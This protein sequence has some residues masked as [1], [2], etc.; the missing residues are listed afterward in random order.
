MPLFLWATP[1][2]SLF[3]GPYSDFYTFHQAGRA[4]LTHGNPYNLTGHAAGFIYP[5]ASL[6][7]YGIFA[8]F[9]FQY[10]STLW[11]VTY[12]SV[13][14]VA[15]LILALTI[16]GER[17]Y[18][19]V[20]LAVLLL[21]TSYP[22]LF[23]MQWGQSDLL[24]AGFAILGLVGERWNHRFTSAALLSIATLLKGPSIVLLVYFVIFRRDLRYF[25]YFLISSLL[26]VGASLL[27]VP[28]GLYWYY[29]TVVV[30]SLPFTLNPG[31]ESVARYLLL[32]MVKLTPVVS[33]AGVFL[34]GGFAFWAGSKNSPVTNHRTLAVDGMFLLNVLIMLQLNV[35][36]GFYHYV[37]V[38]L[39][40]ALFL[41]ALLME[42]AKVE[43][44]ILVGVSTFLLNSVV[45]PDFLR[46]QIFPFEV[47]GNVI[48]TLGIVLMY[49]R[50][51]AIIRTSKAR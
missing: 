37:A 45:T 35:R 22:L 41:S 29:L 50:P 38:I 25:G 16:E 10:A 31:A 14:L 47:V 30:P 8:S 34:F 18:V 2:T 12:F 42:N 17:R 9:D 20:S 32:G 19:Y 13:F 6:P 43:Y 11:F 46:P 49:F 33:L 15:L 39:P 27:V 24:V 44:L 40:L 26:I 1:F 5:P 36:S 4:W 48:L 3:A 51:T 21:L 23:L 28:V 7:F